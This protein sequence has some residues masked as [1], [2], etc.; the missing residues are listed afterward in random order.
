MAQ[1]PARA[2]APRQAPH[3]AQAEEATP[4]HARGAAAGGAAAGGAAAGGA[5]EE[6]PLSGEARPLR[7]GAASTGAGSAS[8]RGLA[9]AVQVAIEIERRT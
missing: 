5:A 1:E 2:P 7:A 9:E 8:S 3:G 6:A 4:L